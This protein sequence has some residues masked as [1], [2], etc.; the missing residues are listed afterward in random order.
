MKTFPSLRSTILSEYFAAMFSSWLTITTERLFLR[1]R[2]LRRPATSI[3]CL[4]SRLAVGS[5]SMSTGVSCTI[6]LAIATF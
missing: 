5:S 6:P 1:D 3:W 4:T 2:S